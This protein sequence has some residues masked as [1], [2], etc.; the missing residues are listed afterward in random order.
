MEKL[1]N[2]YLNIPTIHT[3]RLILNQPVETDFKILEEFLKSS[4]SKYIGGPYSSFTSWSDYMA[5][6]GHWSLYKYGLWSVRLKNNKSFIGRVGLLEP[7]IF[8][9]PDLAW[10]LFKG[11]EGKGY[12]Y[13]AASVV[14]NY[15]MQNYEVS[16]FASHIIKDNK[17]SIMLAEKLNAKKKIEK[18]IGNKKFLVYYYK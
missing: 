4:R 9:E 14:K 10:Q 8:Q 5:N 2:N 12:A 3:D 7:S 13:E 1:N 6:I 16:S 17:K 15:I 18:T 11:F